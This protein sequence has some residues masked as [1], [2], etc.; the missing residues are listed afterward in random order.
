LPERGGGQERVHVN[1]KTSNAQRL[2]SN[3]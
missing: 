3:A 2:T 1:E